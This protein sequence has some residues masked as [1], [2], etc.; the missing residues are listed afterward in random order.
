MKP[1]ACTW[2]QKQLVQKPN[3]RPRRW[4][5]TACREAHRS[6]FNKLERLMEREQRAQLER[7][8]VA[9]VAAAHILGGV[10]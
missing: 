7:A 10:R 3:G 8:E 5:S 1:R 2:C 9:S 6:K 4:C